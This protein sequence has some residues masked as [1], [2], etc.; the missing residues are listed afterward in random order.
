MKT[1][2]LPASIALLALGVLSG[3]LLFASGGGQ[4]PASSRTE[5]CLAVSDGGGVIRLLWPVPRTV[6]PAGGW[7]I[8][9][10]AGKE[11]KRVR[12][13]EV[14]SAAAFPAGENRFAQS[15]GQRAAGLLVRSRN[16]SPSYFV[17]LADIVSD[18]V[19]ARAAGFSA[20]WKSSRPAGGPIGS[21]GLTPDG[22]QSAPAYRSPAVDSSIP[23][24]PPPAPGDG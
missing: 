4:V 14:R 12:A 6:W 23:T 7:Q 5:A 2:H 19:F 15:P 21:S 11:L 9:D 18:P 13:G 20:L 24:P 17:L 3:V 1:T 16:G 10:E 8:L 22:K